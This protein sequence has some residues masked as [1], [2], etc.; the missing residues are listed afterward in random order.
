MTVN[1]TSVSLFSVDVSRTTTV[2]HRSATL[3]LQGSAGPRELASISARLLAVHLSELKSSGPFE[4]K[5]SPEK[6]KAKIARIAFQVG[7][8]G[9]WGEEREEAIWV[10]PSKATA[11][12]VMCLPF[13][14][15]HICGAA[16]FWREPQ[17]S[18][19]LDVFILCCW[20]G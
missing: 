13:V 19:P 15:V 18:P 17:R 3:T 11:A 6:A 2:S 1:H 14:F 16:A 12:V 4:G 9:V 7:G 20:S 5:L 8:G 10:G